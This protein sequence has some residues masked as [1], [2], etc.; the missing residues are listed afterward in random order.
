MDLFMSRAGV[1]TCLL[2]FLYI[3]HELRMNFIILNSFF[4]WK[5][6]EYFMTCEN[7]WHSSFNIHKTFYWH[8]AILYCLWLLL[9][10]SSRVGL[11]VQRPYGLRNPSLLTLALEGVVKFTNFKVRWNW[12]QDSFCTCKMMWPFNEK[13]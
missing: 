11:L 13:W 3:A 5:E 6:E 8:T 2:F 10:Y 1:L 9:H 12:I 4:K 7:I